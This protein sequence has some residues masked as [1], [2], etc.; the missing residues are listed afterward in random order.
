MVKR[1]GSAILSKKCHQLHISHNHTGS[2]YIMNT[3]DGNYVIEKI[4]SEKDLGML[5]DSKLT[6]RDHIISKINIANRNPQ[7]LHVHGY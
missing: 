2:V 7:D 6:F 3:K 4:D 5:F 1:L